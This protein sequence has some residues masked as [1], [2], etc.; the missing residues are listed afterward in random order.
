MPSRLSS[1]RPVGRRRPLQKGEERS[2]GGALLDDVARLDI[3]ALLATLG[4]GSDGLAEREAVSRLER[5]GANKVM[6]DEH[7]PVAYQLFDNLRNPLVILLL[8]LGVISYLTD[9]IRGTIII[10]VMVVLG[11]A[12]RF[13]QERRSDQAA[14]KLK[15]L[16]GIRATVMRDGVR[17]EIPV[18][19]LVPGDIVLLAAG[20]MVPADVRLL[21]AHDLYLNQSALTGESMPV[22]KSAAGPVDDIAG[23][24]GLPM[25]CFQG[26]NVQTG[27]ATAVVVLTGADTYFG[28]LAGSIAIEREQTSF[29]RGVDRFTWLI[30]KFMMVMVPVVFLLNGM[31]RGEWTEAFLFA[32]A[33]AVGMTPEMLPT[34]V[35]VNLSKGA[36]AMA[37]KKVI[38][39]RLNAIQ[40]LGAMDVLCTDKTGT[41]TQGRIVLIKHVDVEGN[42]QEEILHYAYLNSYF[43]TGL[44]NVMDAAV[45]EH[46]R[47]EEELIGREGY[48]KIDEIPFDFERRRLSVVVDDAQGRRTLICKGAVEEVME[49]CSHI[50][51]R[52][53]ALP[54]DTAHHYPLCD[55]L[56]RELNEEGFRV[57]AVAR[58]RMALGER[59]YTAADEDG[60]TLIGYLAFLDPP[61]ESVA[62]A[63]RELEAGGITVKILTGDNDIVTGRI[64]QLVG[65]EIEGVLLGSSIERMSDADLDERVESTTIFAKLSPAHKERIVAA[66]QRRGHVVGF[67]GDGIN[68]APALKRGDVGVSVDTAVDIARESSDIIL[69]ERS[70]E[71]LNDG[72]IEG[73][74]VFG[75]VVKYIKMAASSSFGNMFSVVGASIFIPFLPMLPIQVLANNLL[76]DFSQTTIPTDD[77]DPEWLARPRTWAIDDI[78]RF[79]LRIGP[80]SSIFDY[81]MFII[82]LYVFKCWDNPVLFHTGWFVESLFTQTLIIHVIR[83]DKIPFIESHASTPLIITSIVIAAIGAWLPYSPLAGALGLVALP[84]PYWIFL[85]VMLVCYA[86]LTQVAK[87][88]FLRREPHG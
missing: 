43:E 83:T 18:T 27:S 5:Y 26:S 41:L 47:L 84:W 67:M 64:C 37:R 60:L 80:I 78:R 29:D 17:R 46:E 79:I 72:V 88:R 3:P 50:M 14:R 30:I 75:N 71:V 44:K 1:R 12:L 59:A 76:Y 73:R 53:E 21:A 81:A 62:K 57:V 36:I 20:D 13:V 87:V 63:I 11:V 32:V 33:V 85:G 28:R 55:S 52:G 48:T 25:L 66:L 35:T 15:A 19:R 16:V 70:L 38:V 65:I 54:L 49:H 68:D 69:L 9:D 56:V 7:R 39:K 22:E 31:I 61:K 24:L 86:A 10:G 74:K 77:V 4:T 42:E 6:L 23:P 82:L 2:S 34:I 8:T 45:L 51:V 58:R 40:N